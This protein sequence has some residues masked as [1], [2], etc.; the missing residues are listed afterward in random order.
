M[1]KPE[2]KGW[3]IDEIAMMVGIVKYIE[4]YEPLNADVKKGWIDGLWRRIQANKEYATIELD[5]DF[6]SLV[7]EEIALLDRFIELANGD[8]DY[9]ICWRK[10][11]QNDRDILL[12]LK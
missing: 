9:Q 4:E 6:T 3:L 2:A 1:A 7:D 10:H 12:A 8:K 11:F 5:K